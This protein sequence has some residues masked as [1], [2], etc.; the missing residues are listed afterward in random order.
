MATVSHYYA[1]K[2]SAEHPTASYVLGGDSLLSNPNVLLDNFSTA[3]STTGKIFGTYSSGDKL[4]F[5]YSTNTLQ[6]VYPIVYG[7]DKSVKITGTENALC[8]PSQGI[9]SY[10]GRYKTLT[11]EFWTKIIKPY[12]GSKKI[13]GPLT[14]S[15]DGNGLYV[16]QTS[17][18]FQLGD[19]KGTAPI[20]DFNRPF[21]IQIAMSENN[22]SLIVNGEL[23]IS[24]NLSSTD[25][26]MF[27]NSN[28]VV[29]G[30]GL[31]SF[32]S[33]IYDFIAIYPY[34]VTPEQALRRFVL[35]QGVRFDEHVV[36]RFDGKS[37]VVDY[38]KIGY[39]ANFN[40]PTNSSWKNSIS[41]NLKIE[42]YSIAHR[43]P[44]LPKFNSTKLLSDLE[45]TGVFN[46]KSYTG[47]SSVISNFQIENLNILN[48]PIKAFYMHGFYTSLPS[49]EQVV[50]KAVNQ[51]NGNTFK[52]SINGSTIYYKLK[53]NSGTENTVYSSSST[54]NLQLYSGK[55][56]F[57]V[58]IDIDKFA[59][60]C[61]S[62]NLSSD[63]KNFF[64]NPNDITMYFAGDD[65]LTTD[66]TMSSTIYSVKFLTKDNLD[67]RSAIVSS[68]TGVFYY[69]SA[70]NTSPTGT[71][72]IQNS[73]IGSYDFNLYNDYLNYTSVGY[74]FTVSTN[75]FWKND[76]PLNYFCKT[77]NDVN[78][79]PTS[80]V[81]FI[82]FNIDFDSPILKYTP[83]SKEYFDTTN[84]ESAVKVYVTFE[85]LN[86]TYQPDSTFT[87]EQA[88]TD[89][90]LY[91]GASWATTK[92][93]V[94]NGFI[95]YPP[96]SVTLSELTMI[97]HIEFN[98]KDTLNNNVYIQTMEFSSQSLNANST[99]PIGTQFGQKIIPF[100]YTG[101]SPRV[102]DYKAYNPYIVSKNINPYL[103]MARDSGIRL[104][105]FTNNASVSRG[106]RLPINEM[107]NSRFNISAMQMSL[108]YNAEIN[109]T[110]FTA[111]YPFS[112]EQIFEIQ[113][114]GRLTKFYLTRIGT[115]GKATLSA[116]SNNITNENILFYVNGTLTASPTIDVN[117]WTNIGIFFNDPLIFDSYSGYLDILGKA[118]F[119]NLSYYQL[120]SE[121]F[122][123]QDITPS[124][125]N[126]IQYLNGISFTWSNW[127][128]KTWNDLLTYFGSAL[129]AIQP[130]S[131]YQTFTGTNKINFDD[132]T[133]LITLQQFF[134]YYSDV[135]NASQKLVYTPA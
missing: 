71:A 28:L 1:D 46:L 16:N 62:N 91:P 100:T 135:D 43:Q 116:L 98:V 129:Y 13:V 107:Q 11:L 29:G 87:I 128:A 3:I 5:C 14:T 78:G 96:Q 72:A 60:Y 10:N 23:L 70:I 40:Y 12:L 67:K 126:S 45:A 111:I 84:Y 99:N 85:P 73:I 88:S 81:D 105:G 65:D 37:V 122:D 82:Q 33:G 25:L 20:T 61:T 121:S 108:F 117:T 50:F 56:N 31:L 79:S 55:Y 120:S 2:I 6:T 15:D 90:V 35:G 7:S 125:W 104:V 49:S 113:S 24:L 80:T 9:M 109:T 123:E 44:S 130:S 92:Y 39:S 4:G 32:G 132:N 57:I 26:A 68:A 124:T 30:D 95:I 27:S 8:I 76:I 118:S 19:Q 42:Q 66:M 112:A 47:W 110:T 106:L 77:V 22:A 114:S 58:G 97:I 127:S 133:K 53:Y 102:Y 134:D 69:P 63:V 34:K 38:S 54:F 75:G 52:I 93:E 36:D 115:T 131:M 59:D 21:L 51:K 119:D 89:R 17:F 64:A 103:Y 101:T 94:V 83:S 41:D 86:S 48:T 74:H 18:V